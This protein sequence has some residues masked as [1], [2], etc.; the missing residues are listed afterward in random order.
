MTRFAVTPA[1]GYCGIH[2]RVL[3]VHASWPDALAAR[4]FGKKLSRAIYAVP[5]EIEPGFDFLSH[6]LSP[7]LDRTPQG[8]PEAPYH[9]WR[10]PSDVIAQF[11]DRNRGWFVSESSTDPDQHGP[12]SDKAA[13]QKRADKLNKQW[14][15][16][17]LTGM[18]RQP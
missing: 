12:F 6:M 2:T 5:D 1:P 4:G 9:V 10:Y 17:W 14:Q 3:S 16:R 18:A 7:R 15:R 13:A 11:G 8:M